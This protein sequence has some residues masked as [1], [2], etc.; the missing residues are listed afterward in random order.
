VIAANALRS[1]A[2]GTVGR[3]VA[4]V[5]VRRSAEG[6]LLVKGA[7]VAAGY[8]ADE[9]ATRAHFDAGGWYRTGDLAEIR[10]DGRIVLRGRLRDL[11]VLPTGMNVYPEDVERALRGQPGVA[12]CVVLGMPD[13]AGNQHVHAA[14]RWACPAGGAATGEDAGRAV[15]AAVRGATP[16]WRPTSGS[17]GSPVGGATTSHGRAR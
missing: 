3:P 16:R 8:W 7:N 6:E 5:R 10:A 12:D 2:L 15:A 9:A 13:G 11:I 14:V 1:H 4:G 17:R